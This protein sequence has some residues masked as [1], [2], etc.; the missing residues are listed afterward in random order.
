MAC[1]KQSTSLVAVIIC[2]GR[3]GSIVGDPLEYKNFKEAL[4]G[5][6]L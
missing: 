6:F 1:M 2:Y 3:E 5:T 4:D